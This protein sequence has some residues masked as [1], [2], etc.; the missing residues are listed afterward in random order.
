M[1]MIRN[2]LSGL[3]GAAFTCFTL[4][5]FLALTGNTLGGAG[6]VTRD[7]PYKSGS[8]LTGYELE[9]C[10]LDLYLPEN[11]EQGF[12][13]ILWFHGGGLRNGHKASEI[14][15][16]FA[17]HLVAEGYA[18]ASANYRLSPK[19]K[20]PEYIIDAA[21]AYAWLYKNIERY[22]GSPEKIFVSGHSAGGYLTAMVGLV[23][24]YLSPFGLS[25]QEI[26]GLIPISGQMITHST[27]R[28]ERG[29]SRTQPM[30]DEAA[31]SYHVRELT[32][33]MLVICGGEDVAARAEEN[34]YF[35]SA[36]KAAGNMAVEYKEFAGKTHNTVAS[37]IPSPGS[38][39]SEAVFHFLKTARKPNTLTAEEKRQGWKLLFD[40]EAF[41][42]WMGLGT[43]P[44][45]DGIWTIESDCIRKLKTSELPPNSKGQKV[46][47]ADLFTVETY[48]DYELVFD[49]RISPGGNSG[50]KYNV[51]KEISQW[52][53]RNFKARGF[54]YQIFDDSA[55][56]DDRDRSHAAG[57]L[58][59][60]IPA[61]DKDVRPAGEFNRSRIVFRRNRGEHWLNGV[62]ILEF[63][64]ESAEMKSLVAQSKFKS[65][66]GFADKRS[67]HIV[68]QDHDSEVWFRNIKIKTFDQGANE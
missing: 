28:E 42:G 1:R 63:D 45:A 19:V 5:A 57:G 29:I 3:S 59:D 4:F 56:P 38:P 61:Q 54:E 47:R 40:G 35:L 27:V 34:R 11:P 68:L 16:N 55:L 33:P 23:D 46:E 7:I 18:V 12:G 36:L 30:I 66:P 9:R 22:G 64:L 37:H 21:A 2:R 20:Y 31:P 43:D 65:I 26:A 6:T 8:G 52:G 67:G 44:V 62:K 10:K 49:W 14:A 24:E 39:I 53:E 41:V 51:S 17:E 60:L 58:Y 50:L 25:T 32:P 48:R 15:V 13:S